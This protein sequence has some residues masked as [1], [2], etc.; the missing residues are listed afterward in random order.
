M[1]RYN[2]TV[3]DKRGFMGD[4]MEEH[5]EGNWVRATVA[6]YQAEVIESLQNQIKM[7]KQPEKLKNY[8]V[9]DARAVFDFERAVCIEAFQAVHDKS[10]KKY[11]RKHWGDTD[12][13]LVNNNDEV[14]P[15]EPN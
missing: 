14:I 3:S 12:Y 15:H 10:A 9:M 4:C 6:I 1:K 5:K 8:F 13:V 2:C 7:L 11:I